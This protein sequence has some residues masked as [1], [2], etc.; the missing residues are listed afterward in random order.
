MTIS[1]EELGSAIRRSRKAR[2]LS[3]RQ[4]AEAVGVTLNYVSLLEN[5]KRGATVETLNAIGRVLAVPA[6]LLMFVG[7]VVDD[8]VAPNIAKMMSTAKQLA[9]A[10]IE[11]DAEV[12]S[13]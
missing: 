6:E 9:L 12:K 11:S 8:D 5:G 13:S 4:L 2:G 3:Q 10:A 7:S 1:F